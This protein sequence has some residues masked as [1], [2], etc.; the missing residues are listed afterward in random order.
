MKIS[1][2][3]KVKGV[4]KASFDKLMA[5]LLRPLRHEIDNITKGMIDKVPRTDTFATAGHVA[6]VELT[7]TES[8]RRRYD[9]EVNQW[10]LASLPILRKAS[11]KDGFE[12]FKRYLEGIAIY[13]IRDDF[14]RTILKRVDVDELPSTLFKIKWS[15]EGPKVFIDR[16]ILKDVVIKTLKRKIDNAEELKTIM[17]QFET[18]QGDKECT[19]QE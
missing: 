19:T 1:K 12:A 6:N 2:A 3:K 17:S 14:T 7:W 16:G 8:L 13:N 9:T 5:P 15:T 4:C 10:T 11:I 18:T